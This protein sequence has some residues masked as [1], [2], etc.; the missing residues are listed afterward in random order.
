MRHKRDKGSNQGEGQDESGPNPTLLAALSNTVWKLVMNTSP[1]MVPELMLPPLRMPMQYTTPS[2]V[3]K[4]DWGGTLSADVPARV[5]ETV[6]Y[7][8]TWL[9]LILKQ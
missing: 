8:A 5:N 2:G 6:G 1:R 3:Y 9:E 4:Y 7:A